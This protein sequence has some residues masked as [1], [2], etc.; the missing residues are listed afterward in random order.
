[1]N[2]PAA[3]GDTG[4]YAVVGQ[5]IAHSQSPRIHAMFAQQAGDRLVYDRHDVSPMDFVHHVR[6]FFESGGQGLNVTVP[7]KERAFELVDEL[8]PRAR[9]AGAVNTL[10]KLADGRLQGDNTGGAGLMADL[11]RLGVSVTGRRVLILGAG[12]ATR[13]ILA[14]LLARAPAELLIANRNAARAVALAKDF[15]DLAGTPGSAPTLLR[16]CSLEELETHTAEGAFDCVLHATSLGLQGEVPNVTARVI[17]PH[18]FA[19]DLG[20]GKPDTPFV[21]WARQ[22]GAGGTAQGIGMLIEQAAE[23]YWL[24]H[25]KRPDTAAVHAALA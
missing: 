22:H 14:P 20:Y 8:T 4:R 13:G 7:H 16:G 12:G 17:G 24:W 21:R 15:L 2:L 9:R 1:M 18:T 10:R 23:A 11:D 6:N 19:Y 3:A 5:P 25:G